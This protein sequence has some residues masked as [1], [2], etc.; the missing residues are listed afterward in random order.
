MKARF[1]NE[2]NFERGRNPLDVMEIGNEKMRRIR[3]AASH[4]EPYLEALDSPEGEELDFRKFRWNVDILR[5]ILQVI[6]FKKVMREFEIPLKFDKDPPQGSNDSQVRF[7]YATWGPY[8]LELYKNGPGNAFWHVLY[9]PAFQDRSSQSN[10]LS[11]FMTKL[12]K[13]LKKARAI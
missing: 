2:Q 11:T 12:R 5:E 7:A 9:G 10:K 1:V 4:V 6:V 3:N 8:T 13:A